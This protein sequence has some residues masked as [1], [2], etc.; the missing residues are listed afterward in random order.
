MGAGGA[1]AE[2]LVRWEV[3]V[4]NVTPGLAHSH[5]VTPPLAC[6]TY[7]Q[8]H[9]DGKRRYWSNSYKVQGAYRVYDVVHSQW[10]DASGPPLFPTLSDKRWAL[11][12]EIRGRRTEDPSV[13]N[14]VRRLP[15]KTA[16]LSV[17]V[18]PLLSSTAWPKRPLS[19]LEPRSQSVPPLRFRK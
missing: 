14:W 1:A 3:Y 12:E 18:C 4:S 13:W 17:S 7:L 19:G 5:Q 9:C 10:A 2:V 16:S 6:C 8:H 11:K 15:F